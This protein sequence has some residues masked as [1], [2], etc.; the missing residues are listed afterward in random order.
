MGIFDR[1]FGGR[2][3]APPPEDTDVS[4]AEIQRE[5][6]PRPTAEQRKAMATLLSTL[7][8]HMPASESD[9]L[10]RRIKRL[11]TDIN[12]ATEALSA[13][14]LDDARGQKPEYLTLLSVDWRGFDG[15]EYLAPLAVKASG[16]EEAYEY[17]HKGQLEM[18]QVLAELDGWLAF[19]GRRY[20]HLESGSDTYEGVIVMS[21][22]APDIIRIAGDAGIRFSLTS[23]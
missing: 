15:F 20:L 21:A 4:D 1:L 11:F 22:Q 3:S 2:F 18:V 8:A 5:L 10:A 14:L 19:R 12:G 23:V 13:G 7:F 9:R 17:R 16:L 6:H